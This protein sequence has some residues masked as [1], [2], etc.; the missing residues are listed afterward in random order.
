MSY[1]EEEIACIWLDSFELSNSFKRKM[2]EA[3]ESA[4]EFACNIDKFAP[5]LIKAG[6]S[7][8]YNSMRSSLRDSSYAKSLLGRLRNN[9]IKAVTY[10][11][12]EYPKELAFLREPPLVLYAKGNTSLLAN[13][14]FTIVG[15]RITPPAVM[16]QTQRFSSK[17]SEYM[18]VVTG[19]A[20]GGDSAAINGALENGNLI[21]VLPYG[22]GQ[23]AT[24]GIRDLYGEMCERGLVISEYPYD[25]KAHKF[26]FIER[27]RI[28]AALGSSVLVVSAGRKSGALNTANQALEMGKDIYAFPYSVG[29]EGGEGCNALIKNGAF[30]CDC[31]EDVFLNYGIEGNKGKNEETAMSATAREIIKQ[32]KRNGEMHV[33][34]LTEKVK[35]N[36]EELNSELLLLEME[37]IIVKTGGNK[38]SAV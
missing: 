8:V 36:D 33:Y 30:L 29:T 34:E 7:S 19:I 20:D 15:S 13:K 9:R 22:H 16:R 12:A 35:A 1:T 31:V 38:Y 37:G 24:T 25:F 10:G 17:I 32:L 21:S 11:S 18:T 26:S 3:A 4:V 5:I 27:N 14:K 23:A 28:L 2:L 6:K